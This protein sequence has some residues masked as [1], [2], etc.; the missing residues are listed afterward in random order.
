MM[1]EIY[2][3]QELGAGAIKIGIT[4]NLNASHSGA[5]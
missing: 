3:L 1:Q 4:A 2:F 5:H